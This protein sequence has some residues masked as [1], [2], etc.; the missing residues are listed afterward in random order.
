MKGFKM[1]KQIQQ[2]KEL[3]YKANLF[4]RFVSSMRTGPPMLPQ[5]TYPV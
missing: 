5:S 1:Y 2:L 3:G 4:F